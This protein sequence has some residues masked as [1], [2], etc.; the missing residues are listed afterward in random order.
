MFNFL[1]WKIRCSSSFPK[2]KIINLEIQKISDTTAVTTSDSVE[3]IHYLKDYSFDNSTKIIEFKDLSEE[4]FKDLKVSFSD[5]IFGS[6]IQKSIILNEETKKDPTTNLKN[7]LINTTLKSKSPLQPE[8]PFNYILSTSYLIAS[9]LAISA[10]ML[11]SN[12]F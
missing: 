2:A 11:V 5:N 9:S 10:I 7:A 1:H 8:D 12:L 4:E 3:D 6:Q